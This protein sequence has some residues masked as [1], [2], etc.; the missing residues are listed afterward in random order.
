MYPIIFHTSKTMRP[1]TI[2]SG[3]YTQPQL[4]LQAQTLHKELEKLDKSELKKLM[5]ISDKLA[6][7]VKGKI[8]SWSSA[9]TYRAIE[10]FAGD[11]YTG[12]DANS[13]DED[14]FKYA[15]GRLII[16][17]GLYGILRPLDLIASY[18]LE[19]GYPI[20]TSD[21]KNL[22]EYWR[23]HLKSVL[24]ESEVYLHLSSEEYFKAIRPLIGLGSKVIA[25]VFLTSKLGGVKQVTI[26]SKVARGAYVHWLLKNKIEDLSRLPEFNSLGYEYSSELST[27]LNPTYIKQAN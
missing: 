21:A 17:S 12:L 26:H 16:L 8:D 7:E 10:Y 9:K 22:Y 18:R 13:M 19:M 3:E 25:P 6:D 14:D 15:Q 11:I 4:L 2:E 24:P 5:K 1:P 20:S 23:P 27:E